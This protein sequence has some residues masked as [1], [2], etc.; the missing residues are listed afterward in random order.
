MQACA[1][2]DELNLLDVN[3]DKAV[4]AAC[5]GA[6]TSPACN[7][8][9]TEAQIARFDLLRHMNTPEARAQLQQDLKD[10]ALMNY[11]VLG[12]LRSIKVLD[13]A[14]VRQISTSISKSLFSIGANLTPGVGD[15]KAFAEAEDAW[16]Y[17]F[18]SIGLVPGAGDVFAYG[19]RE[20]RALLKEGKAQEA[21]DLL[22][23][24]ATYASD[25]KDA[26]KTLPEMLNP[27]YRELRGINKGFQAHHTL[28]QYLGEMLGYSRNDMLDHPATLIT[29][30][31]HTGA[32]NPDAMHKAINQ[33]LPPMKEGKK[34][35]YTSGQIKTGLQQAYKDIGRPELFESIKHLIK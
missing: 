3:R 1:R 10:P 5:D 26:G 29:Q 34:A 4:W 17:V 16:D 22:E 35:I 28:P 15:V 7:A 32:I 19:M 11:T 31:A 13:D 14:V 21:S 9:R 23:S 20:S 2:R 18:A 24:L 8:A 12:E 27:T 30:Y 33:Y 25:A 6:A